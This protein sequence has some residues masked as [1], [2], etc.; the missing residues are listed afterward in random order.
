M[1]KEITIEKERSEKARKITLVGFFINSVLTVL[2]ITAGIIGKS[3]AMLADGIHSLSDFFTDIVV[4]VGFKFTEKPADK[5]HNFGH[6]KYETFATFI[7]GIALLLA[8]FDILQGGAS[9]VYKIAFKNEILPRPK[10]IAII[11]ALISIFSKEFLFRF[12]KKVGEKI[13]SP[14][15]IANGWHHR[16]DALSSIGTLIGI[17]VA[18]F[19]GDK[20][21]IFDPIAA[22]VVSVFIFKVAFEIMLPAVNEL[23]ESSLDEKDVKY[24]SNLIESNQ[25]IKNYHNLRTRRIGSNIAIE[26]HLMF[27]KNISLYQAHAIS[28]SIEKT[29]KEYFGNRSIITFHLEPNYK[30]FID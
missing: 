4:L 7:I 14:A 26:A 16:S 29:L 6:E 27:D 1:G 13:N 2:K 17:S 21:I 19:L 25:G 20:W 24:I 18:Y 8:G 10:L 28:E 11:A 22:I 5:D 12:T 3:N 30:E 15:V 9:N 23:L